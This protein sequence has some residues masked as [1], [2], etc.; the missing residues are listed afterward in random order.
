MIFLK[1]NLKQTELTLMV[2]ELILITELTTH[3]YKSKNNN[4]FCH[5]LKLLKPFKM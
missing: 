5:T 4:V 2:T 3:S 1:Q